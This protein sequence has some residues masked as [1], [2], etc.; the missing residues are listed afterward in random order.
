MKQYIRLCLLVA[1]VFSNLHVE[2]KKCKKFHSAVVKCQARIN[3]LIACNATVGGIPFGSLTAFAYAANQTPGIVI[4]DNGDL[5]FSRT[6]S[7]SSSNI[8]FAP[9]ASIF[10]D[11]IVP[12][13][14]YFFAY[15]VSAI[16]ATFAGDPLSFALF[17]N[18]EAIIVPASQ[19]NSDQ[20]L[21]NPILTKGYGI[22]RFSETT[23]LSLRNF[24]EQPI[25]LQGGLPA[26]A[27]AV[28]DSLVLIRI[29]A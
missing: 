9:N 20:A 7:F 29:A 19:Y 16:G 11:I 8:T 18:T 25:V 6:I 4:A 12:S 24:S 23:T 15:S 1:V 5:V 22:A 10:T 17:N 27:L 28:L 21:A 13:G 3:N 14:T 2:A 26:D